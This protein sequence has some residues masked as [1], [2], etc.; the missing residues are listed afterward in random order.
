MNRMKLCV[1][2]S[3]FT[4]AILASCGGKSSEKKANGWLERAEALAERGEYAGALAAIDSLRAN[5][6]DAIE[7]RKKA[8]RLYQEASLEQAQKTI[9]ATDSTLQAV[10]G[11]YEEAKA[12][13]EDLRKRGDATESETKEA[14]TK[15]NNLRT[16]RDSLQAVFDVEC[17][18]VKYIKAKMKE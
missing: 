15:M 13:V 8:L 10:S 9:A 7:T 1:F 14:L 3:A 6:P 11:E 17:A 12:A 5:C 2:A 4:I 16:R 18:K